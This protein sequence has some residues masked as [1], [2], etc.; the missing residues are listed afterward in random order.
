MSILDFRVAF[1]SACY[2]AS[3]GALTLLGVSKSTSDAEKPV[4]RKKKKKK[5]KTEKEKQ[6]YQQKAQFCDDSTFRNGI[7]ASAMRRF[8]NWFQI[9]NIALSGRLE[10]PSIRI[11]TSPRT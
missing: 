3:L 1:T 9:Q 4:F 10:A 6:Q 11:Q 7:V 8:Q 2:C 5:S